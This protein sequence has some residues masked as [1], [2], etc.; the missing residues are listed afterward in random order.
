MGWLARNR[1][2]VC[3]TLLNMAAMGA[4]VLAL[5]WPSRGGVEILPPPSAVPTQAT[6]RVYVSGAVLRADVVLLP[7]GSSVKD[8]ITAAGGAS[9]DADLDAINLA[10]GVRE[11]DQVRVPRVGQP[12]PTAT[13]SQ[14]PNPVTS[15]GINLNTASLEELDT[16]PGIGPVTAQAIID[17]RATHGPFVSIESLLDVRGV[18]E[19]TLSKIRDLI[20]IR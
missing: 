8:A 2:A 16:L 20:S 4:V 19:S 12:T 15:G 7:A 3:A 9:A 13:T 17:Y 6:V 10:A 5:R 18:G 1:V 11:A 14:A